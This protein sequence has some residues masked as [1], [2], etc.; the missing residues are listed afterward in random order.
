MAGIPAGAR[1]AR[2]PK[3]HDALGL[4]FARAGQVICRNCGQLVA[5]ASPATVSQAI[6]AW[7]AGTRYE[8]AFPLDVRPGTDRHALVRS[9]PRRG[10]HAIRVD[11]PGFRT[12]T[13]PTSP[14]PT[15]ASV[16]VI[17]DRLVRGKDP[18]E[19]RADSIETA[20]AK[21]LGRCRVIAGTSRGPY[22]RGWRCSRCGTDHL[23]PQP[24]LFRYNSAH[25]ACPVCEGL[26]RTMELDLA[27]I[28]PDPSKTIRQGAI[29]PWSAPPIGASLKSCIAAAPALDIPVDVPF[30]RSPPTRSSD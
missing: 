4:L 2:S 23:E 15:A 12:R 17:V 7:P 18:P 20:F 19:R 24:N 21:G 30:H 13:S 27:R 28:V 9:A 5:P 26:G 6:D 29:A 8:I 16:E 22:V 14:W 25:G 1:S 11:R 10:L 3:I